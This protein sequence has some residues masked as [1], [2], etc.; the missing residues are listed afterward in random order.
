[1]RFSRPGLT[2]F[3]RVLRRALR[4]AGSGAE[5]V[6]AGA[7]GGVRDE[8]DLALM[9]G[10]GTAGGVGFAALAVLR[11]ERRSGVDVG[12]RPRPPARPTRRRRSRHHGGGIIRRAEP[13]AARRQ[14]AEAPRPNKSDDR[15]R[16][17]RQQ[18]PLPAPWLEPTTARPA[19]DD[20]IQSPWGGMF[21]TSLPLPAKHS[22][23]VTPR[24]VPPLFR[25][26][27]ARG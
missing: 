21:L 18:V 26:S 24:S 6:A 8:R 7:E 20:P 3:S 4:D 9:P 17:G 5:P 13:S 22:R 15:P 14:Q 10:A 23:R 16:L 25:Q 11:A 1:M 19:A 12:R 2:A 27:L